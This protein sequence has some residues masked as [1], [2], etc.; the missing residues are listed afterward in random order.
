MWAEAD[1]SRALYWLPS[2]VDVDG[3]RSGAYRLERTPIFCAVLPDDGVKP[4]LSEL[5]GEWHR[6]SSI[7]GEDGAHVASV[8]RD[9]AGRIFLP[10]DPDE[11]I[12]R[13]W[14]ERYLEFLG[15]SATKALRSAARRTYYRFRPIVP[16]TGQIWAR[17]VFSVV[18]KRTSFPGWPIETALHDLYDLLFGF[19]EQLVDEP[20][21]MI[22]IWP[23]GHRWA[24]ILSH[25]VETAEGF[26]NID[27]LC[28]IEASRGYRSSWNF[29]PGTP[30]D[31][32]AAVI[33]D[34][35][36]R[37]FEVGVHGLYHDGR[38]IADLENRL[39][40]IRA[41]AKEWGAQGFRSP[42]TLRDWPSMPRLGFDYDSTYFDTSPYEPQ[43]GGCCSWLPFLIRDLVELP[44]TLPQDHTL[45]EILGGLDETM[46]LEKARFLRDRG[47]MALALTHPDYA[48]NE[49]LVE[50]YVQLLD[51]FVDDETAWKPLPME[52]ATWWRARSRSELRRTSGGWEID[53]PADGMGTVQFAR[54]QVGSGLDG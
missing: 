3:G 19:V 22:S 28:E 8:W 29:V 35:K 31:G 47:G 5:G 11:A 21:P 40:S 37:G 36:R 17:R 9:G 6:A 2:A 13:F 24:F 44:I 16:R 45:F 46:W 50:A 18:Q 51:E 52:V 23:H 49:R 4:W 12:E 25:D 34:L 14:S 33:D 42:A 41:Y 15:S 38:D 1:E 7:D 26:E 27:L 39:S 54:A 48:T 43:P 30:H 32:R 10:F 53:G 20:I